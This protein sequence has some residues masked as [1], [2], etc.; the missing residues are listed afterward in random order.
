MLHQSSHEMRQSVSMTRAMAKSLAVTC[1]RVLPA[2]LDSRN[3]GQSSV[4]LAWLS[5]CGT[6]VFSSAIRDDDYAWLF[7]VPLQL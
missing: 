7:E 5:V 2:G 4:G 3:S 6:L 1:S